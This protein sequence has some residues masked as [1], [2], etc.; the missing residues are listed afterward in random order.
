MTVPNATSQRIRPAGRC[1]CLSAS[2]WG[3]ERPWLRPTTPALGHRNRTRRRRERHRGPLSGAR[4]LLEM[5]QMPA[6]TRRER[7]YPQ[8]MSTLQDVVFRSAASPLGSEPCATICPLFPPKAGMGPVRPHVLWN[9][10]G[11]HARG[12]SRALST[13][14][15]CTSPRAGWKRPP[16]AHRLAGTQG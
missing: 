11:T 8:C 9:A 7:C 13:T 14:S 12:P 3:Q 15:G 10:T 1:L 16:T 4:L 6:I 2:A 5:P